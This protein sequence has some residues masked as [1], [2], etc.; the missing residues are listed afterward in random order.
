ME[1]EC[2]EALTL[3]KCGDLSPAS[4]SVFFLPC[5]TGPV[6]VIISPGVI[7]VNNTHEA[8]HG[9]LNFGTQDPIT[10]LHQDR[11]Q[12]S[13]DGLDGLDA[14]DLGDTIALTIALSLEEASGWRRSLSTIPSIW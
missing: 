5:N 6:L 4:T 1:I 14:R 9:L 10:F 12:R 2:R 3:G 8:I 11:R 7:E 13:Q